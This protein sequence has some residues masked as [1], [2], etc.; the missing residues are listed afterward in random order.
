MH[1]ETEEESHGKASQFTDPTYNVMQLVRAATKRT[2]D[3]REL[4]ISWSA[5]L[6]DANNRRLDELQKAETKR[7]DEV[8]VLQ[9]IRTEEG[10]KHIS[11]MDKLRHEHTAD[12]ADKD[13]INLEKIRQIDVL[14]RDEKA[15]A[16]ERATQALAVKS[17][18]DADNIRKQVDSTATSIATSTGLQFDRMNNRITTLEQS[19]SLAEGRGMIADPQISELIQEVRKLSLAASQNVGKSDV[20]DPVLLNLQQDV[21]A[22]ILQQAN[23]TGKG[24]GMNQ[25]WLIIVAAIGFTATVVGLISHFTK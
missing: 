3:L 20:S 16:G 17:T 19:K 8:G 9:K 12:L 18:E 10:L 25:L 22:I 2:D 21:K 15:A 1:E 23:S 11:E 4:D 6:Q 13:A 24:M 5:K 14:A 7:M